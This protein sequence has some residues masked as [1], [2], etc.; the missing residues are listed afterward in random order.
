MS[1]PAS[2]IGS[3]WTVWTSRLHGR[4][5]LVVACAAAGALV[6]AA[7]VMRQAGGTTTPLVTCS[8]TEFRALR[9]QLAAAGLGDAK[10]RDGQVH[11]PSTE[12][13]AYQSA[14][15]SSRAAEDPSND[16]WADMWQSATDRLSQ[17]SGTQEREAAR[18]IARAQTIGRL[19]S[20]LPDIAAA[21]VV[22]DE[23]PAAGW[24]EP[25][26]VRA[27]VYLKAEEGRTIGPHVVDAVR[28]AVA[29]SKANLAPADVVVMD[30][31]S[32]ATYDGDEI[33]PRTARAA[34][35]SDGYRR[36]IE[37]ALSYLPGVRVH[38]RAEPFDDPDLQQVAYHSNGVPAE[39]RTAVTVSIPEA[40][41]RQ[42]AG[43]TGAATS[44][45]SARR[46]EVYRSVEQHL[47]ATV[48]EKVSRLVPHD[49]S[50][51]AQDFIYVE[52]L[53][54]P[55]AVAPPADASSDKLAALLQEHQM[56]LLA[57]VTGLAAV[58]VFAS[59]LRNHVRR[60]A[61]ASITRDVPPLAMDLAPKASPI[62]SRPD[63][64]LAVPEQTPEH[65]GQTTAGK[66]PVPAPTTVTG[67]ADKSP[68]H[69]A[70]YAVRHDGPRRDIL[71]D[72]LTR[73]ES[74]QPSNAV[75]SSATS[76]PP[77]STR[78]DQDSRLPRSWRLPDADAPREDRAEARARHDRPAGPLSQHRTQ[79]TDANA[80]AAEQIESLA[81]V[82]PSRLA[83][84]ARSVDLTTWS[85]ALYG[86]SLT[87]QAQILPQLP[88]D[89]AARLTAD[90]RARR[91]IRL[92]DIDEAQSTVLRVWREL[93]HEDAPAAVS[94]AR[95][96]AEAAPP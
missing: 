5:G 11:V 61:K 6:V 43:L 28:R 92:R 17:F 50:V 40:A 9:Q 45:D 13:A 16:R 47:H 21:D 10:F 38:V 75:H 32:G 67:I 72:V 86:T 30:Q 95:S 29:G 73:I 7:A 22:W 42:L 84:L 52:T 90:L 33:D 14:L 44:L 48:R 18:E 37:S 26:R 59:M 15:A 57:V 96:A 78:P 19:L 31:S 49:S 1:G 27:T 56:L 81:G 66:A 35:Q 70:I 2:S 20:D 60:P 39:G 94:A 87:L 41:I 46:R 55:P 8:V 3:H 80:A 62:N 88:A 82:E 68:E 79:A 12:V 65:L 4:T 93:S 69:R 53:P 74:S 58:V 64:A 24:R 54:A 36:E 76:E 63:S 23:T 91:P 71:S 77:A 34:Q 51:A 83:D 89:D 25:A 85:R